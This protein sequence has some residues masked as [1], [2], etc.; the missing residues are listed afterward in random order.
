[1]FDLFRDAEQENG[2]GSRAPEDSPPIPSDF[3]PSFPQPS[4]LPPPDAPAMAN[5]LV[6][7]VPGSLIFRRNKFQL[8]WLH[9]LSATLERLR[10]QGMR[11]ALVVG[12][13]SQTR[14]AARTAHQLGVPSSEIEHL[15]RASSGIHSSLVLRT[16]SKAHP[17]VC[18]DLEETLRVLENDA[19]PVMVGSS[20]PYSTE[21]RA[22]MLAERM[23]G[24]L[25]LLSDFRI[26]E[27]IFSHAQFSRMATQGMAD[28]EAPFILDP[29]AALV[30]AR[31]RIDTFL[32]W[33]KHVD[34]IPEALADGVFEGTLITSTKSISK[35]GV[36]KE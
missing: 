12:E 18:E 3:P 7:C 8:A 24:K 27:E 19:L 21:A 15:N 29:L 23:G 17:H 1:M 33:G 11:V 6:V 35:K 5:A 10:L 2:S 26:P 4:S 36:W 32:I 22:A 20:G 14:L 31:S 9:S 30:M 16:L 25:I 34:H 13:S 28:T